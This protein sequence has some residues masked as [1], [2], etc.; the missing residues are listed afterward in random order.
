METPAEVIRRFLQM[1]GC[2]IT[3][4]A[5]RKPTSKK[6]RVAELIPFP[7]KEGGK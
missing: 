2:K 1:G 5:R 3:L 7:K 4:T 6:E